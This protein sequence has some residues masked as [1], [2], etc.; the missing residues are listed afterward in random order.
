MKPTYAC[1]TLLFIISFCF[2]FH[3]TTIAQ[4][5]LTVQLQNLKA[6]SKN[7]NVGLTWK[8]AAEENLLQF[9]IEYSEDGRYYHN[10]GFIPAGNNINGGFYEFE[11]AVT[12][13][14]SAFY[15]LKIVD[16]NRRLI[17]TTPVLYHVNNTTAF[18][19]YPSVVT[20]H[21]LNLFL[22][23][24]F[25]FLEVVTMSGNIILKQ[26]LSGKTGRIN[27]PLSSNLRVGT[28]IVKLRDYNRTLVQKIIIQ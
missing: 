7:G 8:T 28:Y 16:N 17:Y 27:V 24:P 13:S 1:T 19:I 4:G 21:V 12:Y 2:L 9:E 5:L 6:V 15:R 25:N 23:D 20:S 10:L 14:D 3:L 26:N 18:M 22:K 11:H